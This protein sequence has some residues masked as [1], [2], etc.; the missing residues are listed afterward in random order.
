MSGASDKARFFVTDFSLFAIVMKVE[1]L[2]FKHQFP[3]LQLVLPYER[4]MAFGFVDK[5][6]GAIVETRCYV[7]VL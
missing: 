1:R 6:A 3:Q 5:L 2:G 4:S 7:T